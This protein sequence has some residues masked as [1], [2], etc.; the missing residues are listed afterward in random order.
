MTR[1]VRFVVLAFAVSSLAAWLINLWIRREDPSAWQND[2]YCFYAVGEKL[3]ADG[4]ARLYVQECTENRLWLYPPYM[5]YPYALLS[6]LPPGVA[7]I[8]L[9][10]EVVVL[11]GLGLKLL[12][13]AFPETPVLDTIGPAVVASAPFVA[14]LVMGQHAAILFVA[15]AGGL[16]GIRSG[17]RFA[18]GLFLGLLGIKPNWAVVFV[19]WLLLTRRWRELGGM[20]LVG[21][22]MVLSTLP[23][24]TDVWGEYLVAGPRGVADLLDPESGVLQYPAH[25]LITFEAFSRS[26][27]G[28]LSPSA[29]SLVWIALQLFAVLAALLTWFK[30]GDV[31]DQIAMTVLVAVSAN[32]Y[33]E[34]Y[35]GLALAVPAA[36]WWARR[37]RDPG[38]RWNGLGAVL[39]GLWVYYWIW[40]LSMPG[41]DWPSVV[42]VFLAVW[43]G[44]EA[45][46]FLA[47]RPSRSR[48]DEALAE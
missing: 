36:V 42:G 33:V 12:A 15:I 2:W 19:L 10:V 21:I 4:P 44:Y 37:S 11:T 14:T 46:R 1:R 38:W 25:K 26:T 24:G 16:W 17:R 22:L 34:F 35:D 18:G 29:G 43:M 7:Y 27:I 3:L 32:V 40:A 6:L 41:N 8:L 23:L 47:M 30:T 39:G 5:M 31:R 13:A 20:A 48:A 45:S 9:M 28:S